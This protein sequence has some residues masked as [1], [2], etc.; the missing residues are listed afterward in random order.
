MLK[1]LGLLKKMML[2]SAVLLTLAYPKRPVVMGN[3]IPP[4]PPACEAR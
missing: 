1:K 4:C 3:P 2:M